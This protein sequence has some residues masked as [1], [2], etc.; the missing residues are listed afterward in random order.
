MDIRRFRK[1][2]PHLKNTGIYFDHAAVS[3]LN[4][5]SRALLDTYLNQAQGEKINNYVDTMEMAET[6]RGKIGQL[7]SASSERIALVR[8]TT[9]GLILLARGLQWSSGDRIILHRQ[10]FPSNVYPWWELQPQGV[11]IDFIDTPDGRVTPADLESVVTPKTRLLA[12][13]WVQYFNGYRNSIADLVS[14]CHER[15]I[16]VAVDAMQGLGH[17]KMDVEA[18]GFDFMATG[19][20]KWLLG[21]QGLGFVYITEELQEA[22]HPPHLGWQSRETIWDF[23]NYHQPLKKT[24]GRYEFATPFSMGIWWF[25]GSLDLLL[26]AGP[27]AIEKRVLSLTDRLAEGLAQLGLTIISKRENPSE[28]SGIIT[29]SLPDRDQNQ[30][31]YTHLFARGFVVS[32]RNNLLRIAPHFYNL[33][34][35]VDR[36][37]EAI[38]RFID[39]KS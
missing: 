3:P 19:T 27:E 15:N 7:I 26:D 5:R 20:A 1:D 33:E 4:R 38:R 9:D 12:V 30:E 8:N 25:S 6:V 2:F 16:L 10:E 21:P 32:I 35:E 17:L 37:I 24:A 31:L 34:S 23:H 39:T 13:S 36:F 28:K 29:V 14:W 11:K 22:I 18:V